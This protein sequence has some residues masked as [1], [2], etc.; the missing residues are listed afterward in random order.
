MPCL[1]AEGLSATFVQVVHVMDLS[2]QMIN[3]WPAADFHLA[4]PGKKCAS[5]LL[6]DVHAQ[7][8]DLHARHMALFQGMPY[9]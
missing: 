1:C 5:C 8:T 7:H 4:Y 2:Y 6:D 9:V 3:P